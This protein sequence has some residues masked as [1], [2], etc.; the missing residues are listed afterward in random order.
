MA[1][2]AELRCRGVD[3][4]RAG[5]STWRVVPGNSGSPTQNV[6]GKGNPEGVPVLWMWNASPSTISNNASDSGFSIVM[7]NRLALK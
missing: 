1:A 3:M 6:R 4:A 7:N 5:V 2:M